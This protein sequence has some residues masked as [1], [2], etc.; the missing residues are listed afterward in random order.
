MIC[1]MQTSRRLAVLYDRQGNGERALAEYQLALQSG[2]VDAA[3]LNDFG[4]FCY[5]RG[6][7]AEAEKYLRQAVQKNPAYRRAWLWTA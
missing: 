5:E 1:V 4:Y 6:Q 7:L 3:L 2:P